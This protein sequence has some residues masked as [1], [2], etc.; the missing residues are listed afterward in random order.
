MV[1]HF[2]RRQYSI[3][4]GD[5]TAFLSET[6]QHFFRRQYSI[7]FGDST[8]FLSE[9]LQHSFRKHYSISFGDS[10]AFLSETVQH[11]FKPS[12]GGIAVI[13]ALWILYRGYNTDCKLARL[14]NSS[15]CSAENYAA[16]TQKV[17]EYVWI[18]EKKHTLIPHFICLFFIITCLDWKFVHILC[19]NSKTGSYPLAHYAK[20][21]HGYA[22]ISRVGSIRAQIY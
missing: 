11:F 12:M 16:K 9:T 7:P 4:F 18:S 15:P 21:S 3:P 22:Q 17:N 20:A 6:V 14:H 8:A 2:F 10:T 5:I 1:Q 13:A 19:N